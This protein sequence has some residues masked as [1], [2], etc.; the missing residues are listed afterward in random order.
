MPNKSNDMDLSLT[1]SQIA[2]MKR[3]SSAGNR[4]PS[5]SGSRQGASS[6][7]TTPK[8]SNHTRS[9]SSTVAGESSAGS[10]R[11]SPGRYRPERTNSTGGISNGPAVNSTPSN[12]RHKRASSHNA[13]LSHRSNA[14]ESSSRASALSR[15]APS[16]A[17]DFLAL[18][19]CSHQ[20]VIKNRS[21]KPK[22]AST[23]N[24][25]NEP[26]SGRAFAIPSSARSSSTIDSYTLNGG[27]QDTS[28]DTSRHSTPTPLQLNTHAAFLSKQ[29]NQ[30]SPVP[31]D[32]MDLL[33]N[34]MN[35]NNTNLDSTPP[36]GA[37]DARLVS[38]SEKNFRA[39][40]P[41]K[42]T[43]NSNRLMAQPSTRASDA[44]NSLR[45]P[46]RDQ[47]P[48]SP[49]HPI[50]ETYIESVNEAACKIQRWYRKISS[51]RRKE[52][53]EE[54]RR[55]L[56]QKRQEREDLLRQQQQEMA[57]EL[58]KEDQR[59]RSREE[60]ARLA[61][62]AAIEELQK[63]REVRARD[64]REKAEEELR[65]L[66]TSGKVS[67][68]PTA[69]P[70]QRSSSN[71]SKKQSDK[72]PSPGVGNTGSTPNEP[73]GAVGGAV[74]PR[75]GTAS[76][77]GR[78]VDEIFD[79]PST[80]RTQA[81]G[82]EPA[83]TPS[84]AGT[85]TTLTD[86][87][88]T[89]KLLE[90]PVRVPSPT[91]NKKKGPAWLDILDDKEE[92]EVEELPGLSR[93]QASQRREVYLS[94]E[95]LQQVAESTKPKVL[96]PKPSEA[97]PKMGSPH[98]LL[99]EDKLKSIMSFLDEVDQAD[100][101][102]VVSQVIL[103]HDMAS[104]AG[105]SAL[106][107][108]SA[109]ELHKLEQASAAASEVTNTVLSQR[110]Q[111]EEKERS[112][113]ML[114]KALNQQRE[115]TVRHA[116]EQ[117]KEM[118][119]RLSVQKEEY[120]ATVKRHLSFIDQLIDD[121][122]TLS[123]KYDTVVKDLKAVDKKYQTKMKAMEDTHNAELQKVKDVQAAAEKIRREK[124]ID[125]KT[126]KIKEITVKGLEPEI[127]RLI[128]SHKAE[129]KKL[130]AIHEAELLQAE[131]RAG[132]KYVRHTEE[133]RDQLAEEK[134]AACARE[135]EL[136]KT[137]YE[138]QLEQEEAA[139][140]QQRRRLYADIQEE[141]ERLAEQA[142]RQ[143]QEVDRLTLQMEENSRK[144]LTAMK[145]EYEQARDE[146][147]CRHRAEVK[148]LEERLKIEKEAWEE[149]YMKKQETWLL[150]KEREL[151]EHVRK[152]RDKEI[153]LVI[154]RLEEDAATGREE[155]ERAAENRVKRIRDKYEA[156]L[157]EIELSERNT[158]ERYN[159]MKARLADVEGENI[160]ISGLMK[161]KEQEVK[162]IKK[163]CD[164]LTTERNNVQDVIR[165]EFADRLVATEEENKRVKN[166]MSEMRA[167]HKLELS[168]IQ[169]SKEEEMEEVHKRVKQA[170]V[171]KEET[172]NQ[173]RQQ[174]AAAV[175]RADHLESLLEQQR[176]QLLK[177]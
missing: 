117:E 116:K 106:L 92:D 104:V 38:S 46:R 24:H 32:A 10:R 15:D 163:I 19:D 127:Q 40:S 143:R 171:K 82:E 172:V 120:E 62:Q 53:E 129:I 55:I 85:K 113:K 74:G 158:Q 27:R 29:E 18:F 6:G 80:H 174:H 60:K 101:E 100:R 148:D 34:S 12:E 14:S 149:N 142:K 151:K 41:L 1:G 162:D 83:E 154:T 145:E 75:P 52:G 91:E 102:E 125:E 131:E 121:K 99:T 3:P 48:P 110:L 45:T 160:R 26:P 146:Q 141:K 77:V 50:A 39:P 31:V 89:L 5:S 177:K 58:K 122:K 159:E 59:K 94:A 64:I 139:Y 173:L 169:E 4:P 134:E 167:R 114:Q 97:G 17:T 109:A 119:K 137:R 78:K 93:E 118:K 2:S 23:R 49:T 152:D 138:K 128:A 56:H 88:D 86:L 175:K 90:E 153:E 72:P 166:E 9:N 22:K 96:G 21:S 157:R 44:Q 81:T 47:V 161:Q 33:K 165:Q 168:R 67:K 112:V 140:Q 20:P 73:V 126:K 54:I 42:P 155:C 115:L 76:S 107:V 103:S 25:W 79:E 37:G 123:E 8:T 176:K 28:R 61:R 150:S 68:K 133:L 108:P 95:N 144:A 164:R 36:S 147:E 57:T 71:A 65:F 30:T 135:R 111:L 69:K 84:I 66:Q 11:P 170:I 105:Q 98:A 124:W 13:Q 43:T 16:S 35:T 132:G 7:R 70:R 51:T 63:K 130:K 87:L 136:A 156:E